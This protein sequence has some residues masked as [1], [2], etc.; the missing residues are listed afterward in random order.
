M[1]A[2]KIRLINIAWIVLIADI[3]LSSICL[4][5]FQMQTNMNHMNVFIMTVKAANKLQ[6]P[7]RKPAMLQRKTGKEP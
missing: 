3:R 2:V 7:L 5:C 1:A 4:I 6:Q